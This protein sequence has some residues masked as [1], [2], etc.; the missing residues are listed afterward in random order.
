MKTTFDRKCICRWGEEC[1]KLQIFFTEKQD[2]DPRGGECIRVNLEGTKPHEVV[3]RQE[4]LKSLGVPTHK[5]L[6]LHQVNIARHHWTVQQNCHFK[7][8]QRKPT[9]PVPLD[10]LKKKALWSAKNL[11]QNLSEEVA[12]TTN[13]KTKL[14]RDLV[15]IM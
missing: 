7:S 13:N 14:Y 1:R 5:E 8:K 4:F 12:V 6:N 3:K 2:E 15:I 11:E 9:H 10:T